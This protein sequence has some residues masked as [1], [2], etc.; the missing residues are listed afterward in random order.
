[1]W[2]NETEFHLAKADA[3]EKVSATVL[4]MGFCLPGTN[5]RNNPS[6]AICKVIKSAADGTVPQSIDVLWAKGNRIRDKRMSECETYD[7]QYRNF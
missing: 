2:N 5:S 7:Y 4:Y 3:I 6:W 1:M